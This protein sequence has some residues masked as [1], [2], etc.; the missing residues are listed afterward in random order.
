MTA[1]L[2]KLQERLGFFERRQVLALK[3]LDERQL[4]YLDVIRFPDDDRYF[5]QT[6]LHGGVIATL[7]G[8]DLITTETLPHHERLDDSFLTDRGHELG[9]VTHY[10]AGLVRVRVEEIDRHHA[11]NRLTSGCRERLDVVMVMPHPQCFRQS[12][13]RH[14]R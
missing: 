14:A 5:A 1:L 2:L 10:L 6:D 7:A 13:L 12:A 4:H 3:I 9:Q 11:T 8:D